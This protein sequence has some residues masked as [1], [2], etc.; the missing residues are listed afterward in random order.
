MNCEIMHRFI[1]MMSSGSCYVGLVT[2]ILHIHATWYVGDTYRHRYI[3]YR[4]MLWDI[5]VQ[6]GSYLPT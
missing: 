5:T 1:S 6:S 3:Y 2:W 4:Y